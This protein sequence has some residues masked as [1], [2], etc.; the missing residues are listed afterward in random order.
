VSQRATAQRAEAE[1]D[2]LEPG[3]DDLDQTPPAETPQPK[4]FDGVYL[5]SAPYCYHCHKVT[6]GIYGNRCGGLR[7]AEGHHPRG[8]DVS[9][10][11]VTARRADRPGGRRHGAR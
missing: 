3:Q 5:K 8:D 9:P 1:I 7:R 11:R 2:A 10:S 6:P 4:D